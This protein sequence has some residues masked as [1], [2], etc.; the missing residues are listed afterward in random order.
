MGTIETVKE[1]TK[2]Y[3]RVIHPNKICYLSN[4]GSSDD[5]IVRKLSK[6]SYEKMAEANKPKTLEEWK[7]LVMELH[8]AL[9]ML[10]RGNYKSIRGPILNRIFGQKGEKLPNPNEPKQV[11]IQKYETLVNE[12]MAV[13]WDVEHRDN[14]KKAWARPVVLELAKVLKAWGFS[15]SMWE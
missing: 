13:M 2:M 11:Q 15:S 14:Y 1:K 7:R 10:D 12:I 5:D 8:P 6:G 3:V 9:K 4:V